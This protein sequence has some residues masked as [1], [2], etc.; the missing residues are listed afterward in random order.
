MDVL[1]RGP[2]GPD[3]T[4]D[5]PG[6]DGSAGHWNG[7][8]RAPFYGMVQGGRYGKTGS[9]RRVASPGYSYNYRCKA[10][11]RGNSEQA[12]LPSGR[13]N[14]WSRTDSQ[15]ERGKPG[16]VKYTTN[17][18]AEWVYPVRVQHPTGFRAG[19]DEP[20]RVGQTSV[21]RAPLPHRGTLNDAGQGRSS[22]RLPTALATPI[23]T[24]TFL[25]CSANPAGLL[26]PHLPPFCFHQDKPGSC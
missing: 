14:C 16:C 25:T 19:H 21:A 20:V 26:R 7:I 2:S 18:R 23:K 8:W 17:P 1:D 24:T 12:P 5:V 3:R 4:V 9:I 22:F 11:E 6:D 15:A 13:R 10:P